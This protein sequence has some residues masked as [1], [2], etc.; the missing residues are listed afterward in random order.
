VVG[1]ASRPKTPE[2]MVFIKFKTTR[3]KDLE[4]IAGEA[5][6]YCGSKNRKK[7]LDRIYRQS[8]DTMLE[9][10]R[11][12]LVEAVRRGDLQEAERLESIIK[13]YFPNEKYWR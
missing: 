2:K 10:A 1:L 7:L 6:K 3:D 5:R 13:R 4:K 12:K 11:K 8:K 9:D